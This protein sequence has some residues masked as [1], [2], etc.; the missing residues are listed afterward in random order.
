MLQKHLI[1]NNL[2]NYKYNEFPMQGIFVIRLADVE[3]HFAYIQDRKGYF[4]LYFILFFT[5][6]SVIEKQP[7]K[8]SKYGEVSKSA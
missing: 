1:K 5:K 7:K 4:V 8:K 6:K 2:P 3:A